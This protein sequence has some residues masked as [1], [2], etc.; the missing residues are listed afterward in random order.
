MFSVTGKEAHLNSSSVFCEAKYRGGGEAG[1]VVCSFF[2]TARRT[3]QEA[4]PLLSGFFARS[5]LPPSGAAELAA[6]KQSSPC[7]L[8]RQAPSRPDKGGVSCWTCLL[9]FSTPSPRNYRS[10]VSP[11]YRFTTQRRSVNTLTPPPCVFCNRQGG[12]F[13]LLLCV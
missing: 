3:N 7:F 6:L 9:F 4:P 10:S 2:S 5:L 1:G 13:K 12:T 11:L 8:R